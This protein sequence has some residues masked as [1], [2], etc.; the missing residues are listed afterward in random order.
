MASKFFEHF[1]AIADAINTHGGMGLWDEQDGFYYDQLHLDGHSVP[2]KV[3]SLVGLI[4][5]LAVEVLE[6]EIIDKLPG[7]RKRMDWFLKN[8]QDLADHI[9]YMQ[10]EAGEATH[11]H[12][13]L[14][15]PTR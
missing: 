5:L 14:A 15:I 10:S 12:R 3:R 4:P 13:L 7:F 6:D 1:V 2:L 9:A 11:G 8:R